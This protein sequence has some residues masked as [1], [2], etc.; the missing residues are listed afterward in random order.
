MLAAEVVAMTAPVTPTSR[1]TLLTGVAG[2]GALG[3]MIAPATAQSLGDP[4]IPE[5]GGDFFLKLAGIRGSSVR[6]GHEDEIESLT[7]W[8]GLS[9]G[10][11][12]KD[13]KS[14]VSLERFMVAART[15]IHSPSLL[16]HLLAARSIQSGAFAARRTIEGETSDYLVIH[17]GVSQ[18]VDYKV[19]PHPEEGFA[20]DLVELRLST[21]PRLV[22][23]D[24]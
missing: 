16:E 8:W 7:F 2:F 3:A 19:M 6:D 18:V 22:Y 4:A 23:D 10:D 9:Q 13:G 21:A 15:G 14:V 5:A 1:R 24:Q 20:M 12:T 11:A 17:L